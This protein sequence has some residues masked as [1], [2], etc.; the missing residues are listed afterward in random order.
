MTC[1]RRSPA[2]AQARPEVETAV[3]DFVDAG[4]LEL[5]LD[6][7]R[8]LF[9]GQGSSGIAW[10]RCFLPA[11]FM[12]ADWVGC[13]GE[14]PKLYFKTGLVKRSTQRPDFADYDVVVLQQ[15]RGEAWR[16]AIR[17]F[18]SKG[19]KVV[20]EIDDYVHAIHKMA[21]HDFRDSFPKADLPQ[22]DRC[23]R[24]AD[25]IFVSTPYLAKR[26]ASFNERVFVCQN[27]VDLARYNLTR[28]PR[29]TVNIGWA[30]GTGHTKGVMPW[31][32]HTAAVMERH[33]NTCFVS[34]GQNF[35]D[36][37]IPHFGPS[38]AVSIPWC[39]IEVYP[40]AMTMFDVALAPAGKG[41][42]FKG[43]SDLRWVEA[44]ALGIPVVA[45]PDVYPN[46]EPGVTG[47]HATTPQEAAGR[48]EELIADPDLRTA[49]GEAAR[50]E[51]EKTR[52]MR[53]VVRQWE[54][55]LAQIVGGS[56]YPPE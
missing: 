16:K 23:M 2:I 52:D 36:A 21:D 1:S 43:K 38:R 15:V 35:A 51:I 17:E 46:I 19:I 27:G 24:A 13:I 18:Q 6:P 3:E 37:F 7:R 50:A 28:P 31:L 11:L 44:S 54:R 56:E 26:Y 53:V 14:P 33:D 42:F 32:N 30:G 10:Y 9:I 4:T 20:Y 40:A 39:P 41:L 47:F 49:V 34:I 55:A 48:L 29:P 25:A 5:G 12:G 22:I 8:V 45:D